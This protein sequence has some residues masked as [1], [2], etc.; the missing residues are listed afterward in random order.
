MQLQALAALE[1]NGGKV[2]VDQAR[3][4]RLLDA[5]VSA[6]EHFT[7]EQLQHVYSTL[8]C[9]IFKHRRSYDKSQLIQVAILCTSVLGFFKV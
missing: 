9:A 6:T 3:L 7:I 2:T 5:T 1:E 8:S 4:N